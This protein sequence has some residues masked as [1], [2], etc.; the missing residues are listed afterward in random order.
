MNGNSFW[1]R[2]KAYIADNPK[3]YWFK[4]KL[5]GWGWTPATWEGWGVIGIY[6]LFLSWN[7]GELNAAAPAGTEPPDAAVWKFLAQVLVSTVLLIGVFWYKGQKPKWQWG[8]PKDSA[9]QK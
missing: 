1:A 6:L 7:V 8:L 9:A 2:Y 3:G 4:R 5:Y